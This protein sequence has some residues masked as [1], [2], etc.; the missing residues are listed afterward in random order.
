MLF[1]ELASPLSLSFPIISNSL[2]PALLPLLLKDRVGEREE[3]EV[4]F[5][6]E[7]AET[8]CGLKPFFVCDS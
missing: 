5:I 3:K 8:G 4:A 6:A 1:L 2:L 7:L